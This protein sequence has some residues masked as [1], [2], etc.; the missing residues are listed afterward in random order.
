MGGR[1]S[2]GVSLSNSS[3][4][5]ERDDRIDV[6]RSLGRKSSPSVRCVRGRGEPVRN[7]VWVK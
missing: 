5:C 2:V 4:R 6:V 1:K 3:V 7:D